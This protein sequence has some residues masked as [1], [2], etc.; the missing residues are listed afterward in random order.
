MRLALFTEKGKGFHQHL[1]EGGEEDP[2][3]EAHAPVLQVVYIPLNPFAQFT[4]CAY[5]TNVAFYLRHTCHTGLSLMAQVVVRY[6][7]RIVTCMIK[8]VRARAY[9]THIAQEHIE[10]L[11]SF[12]EVCFAKELAYSRHT[13]IVVSSLFQVCISVY[14]HGA[15]LEAIELNALK[16]GSFLDK[17]YGTF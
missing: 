12:I 6:A 13:G 2:D 17:E 15:E 7:L 5:L 8:H 16:T 10:E 14:T 1:S 9:D 4:F 3:I 11:S